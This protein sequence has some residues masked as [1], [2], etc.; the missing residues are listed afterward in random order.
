MKA[1]GNRKPDG[2]GGRREGA[3]RKPETLSGHQVHD[4]LMT[5]QR[6][7]KEQDKTIDD[8]LMFIIYDK[9]TTD[10]ARLAAIK[11]FKDYTIPKIHEGGDTDKNVGPAVFLP[12]KH[13]RL[14]V[15][16][17]GKPSDEG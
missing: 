9:K 5:A 12:E 3:G 7:A 17:G 1:S 13:P 11:C 14:E 8:I 16:D 10:N 6:W 15:I 4:M 2:R